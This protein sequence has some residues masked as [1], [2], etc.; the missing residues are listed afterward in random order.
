[1]LVGEVPIKKGS[2]RVQGKVAYLSE[3]NFFLIDTLA[4]NL[5]FYNESCTK[6][7]LHRVYEELGLI[8]ELSLSKGLDEIV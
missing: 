4:N 2:L 3:E 8:D 7:E 1:M 6:L 5:S